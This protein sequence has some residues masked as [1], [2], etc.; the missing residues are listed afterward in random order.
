MFKSLRFQRKTS[1][2][3]C[4]EGQRLVEVFV[5]K[6][7]VFIIDCTIQRST[8]AQVFASLTSSSSPPDLSVCA[9]VTYTQTELSM[10]CEHEQCLLHWRYTSCDCCS[11]SPCS[12]C[13]RSRQTSWPRLRCTWPCWHTASLWLSYDLKNTHTQCCNE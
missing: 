12:R 13:R 5:V 6:V 9:A 8:V 3:L 11:S 1:N 4:S 2:N 7:E 10:F